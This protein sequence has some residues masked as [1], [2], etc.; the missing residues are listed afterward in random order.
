MKS[1]RKNDGVLWFRG[2]DR[3]R[4]VQLCG[5]KSGE[6][7]G[8]ARMWLHGA[9]RDHLLKL[10]GSAGDAGDVVRHMAELD[11][12]PLAVAGVPA[13][14]WNYDAAVDARRLVAALRNANVPWPLAVQRAAAAYAAPYARLG[15]Y[16]SRMS[17][18]AV[19]PQVVDDEGLRAV[20]DHSSRCTQGAGGG[21]V[22]KEW[23]T[24][25]GAQRW[26]NR[27]EDGQFAEVKQGGKNV[28]VRAKRKVEEEKVEADAE[29]ERP[30]E[31]SPEQLAAVRNRSGL[32]ALAA[33]R[34]KRNAK[35][36]KKKAEVQ[37]RL[38]QRRAAEAAAA[39]AT[40]GGAAQVKAGVQQKVALGSK[41]K[42]SVGQKAKLSLKERTSLARK[43]LS[44][45]RAAVPLNLEQPADN[46]IAPR[47][48]WDVDV[49]YT[50]NDV[51]DT[52]FF[53][54]ANGP[55]LG[56][57]VDSRG[58]QSS[59][60][61]LGPAILFNLLNG[62][63]RHVVNGISH[64]WLRSLA[65][66]TYKE[67][68]RW[69]G[70][71]VLYE[72][73]QQRE[74]E[75]LKYT[76]EK[77]L[78]SPVFAKVARPKYSIQKPGTTATEIKHVVRS[79]LDDD[80][81]K[82]EVPV[83]IAASSAAG[84]MRDAEYSP[85]GVRLSTEKM[86]QALSSVGLIPDVR[87]DLV[88]HT[89]SAQNETA[90]VSTAAEAY[91]S[92]AQAMADSDEA[93]PVALGG[94]MGTMHRAAQKHEARVRLNHSLSAKRY[95]SKSSRVIAERAEKFK[96]RS[97]VSDGEVLDYLDTLSDKEIAQGGGSTFYM[98]TVS[99]YSS[100]V[101]VWNDRTVP[102]F[103]SWGLGGN[104]EGYSVNTE[105]SGLRRSEQVLAD[106][107]VR[108]AAVPALSGAVE[109][110]RDWEGLYRG[111]GNSKP[112]VLKEPIAWAPLTLAK[113][114]NL[115]PVS[116]QPGRDLQNAMPQYS[117]MSGLVKNLAEAKAGFE[118]V[119]EEALAVQEFA[120]S[121]K[122]SRITELLPIVNATAKTLEEN[123]KD[124]K[125]KE[126]LNQIRNKPVVDYSLEMIFDGFGVDPEALQ[127]SVV[128]AVDAKNPRAL[129]SAI[130]D[131]WHLYTDNNP[132]ESPE[133]DWEKDATWEEDDL[134]DV[135]SHWGDKGWATMKALT[136]VS[137]ALAPYEQYDIITPVSHTGGLT[138]NGST[139]P[140]RFHSGVARTDQTPLLLPYAAMD[141]YRRDE[142]NDFELSRVLELGV[143]SP[144]WFNGFLGILSRVPCLFLVG[145]RSLAAYRSR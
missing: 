50:A 22:S 66:S 92:Y 101:P 88:T 74:A 67:T 63:E 20:V 37:R 56:Y 136:K 70:R 105:D 110:L 18:K 94:L 81:V 31:L 103:V 7:A 38:E 77:L 65:K 40:V 99:L 122:T 130:V 138:S 91:E 87:A 11:V 133:E 100:N 90:K 131:G 145:H 4:V 41:K 19:P 17:E 39:M 26:V 53:S 30:A 33:H 32:A 12:G 104:P 83:W 107:G 125:K 69:K 117:E 9:G 48:F 114:G 59:L 113:P 140:T 123:E 85:R 124:V 93:A 10:A 89:F 21:K 55:N 96:D 116:L 76:A 73:D 98:P 34:K 115:T 128:N 108:T 121:A 24:V 46:D 111:A 3:D 112:G 120:V 43:S 1:L 137:S 16:V 60:H 126:H 68:E 135:F 109:A 35:R 47:N 13:A 61:V 97:R 82:F 27:D 86:G 106:G 142:E 79:L 64:N 8:V 78:D 102:G 28:R 42:L 23:I 132:P 134:A 25:E 72:A 58:T 45:K 44:F 119:K 49:P 71:G 54:Y 5:G 75:R 129:A 127:E 6:A 14:E 118:P 57:S 139:G 2:G 62:D 141:I 29:V 143:G 80:S 52:G 36:A 15:G 51:G 84:T 144:T 95:Y